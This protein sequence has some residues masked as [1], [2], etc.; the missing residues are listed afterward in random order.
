MTTVTC[1]SV[2]LRCWTRL[3]CVP[4]LHQPASAWELFK[5]TYEIGDGDAVVFRRAT[6]RPSLQVTT[7]E[8]V[9]EPVV[10]TLINAARVRMVLDMMENA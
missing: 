9:A 5:V 2:G 7:Y 10:P 8:E 3:G 4:V 6:R 1:G